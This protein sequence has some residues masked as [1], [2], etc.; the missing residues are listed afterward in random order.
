MVLQ[1]SCS[2]TLLSLLS[3]REIFALAP[4]QRQSISTTATRLNLDKVRFEE[5][6][7]RQE[8]RI[9]ELQ[10]LDDTNA[11]QQAE[12]EGLQSKSFIEQYDPSSFTESHVKFKRQHNLVFRQL[13]VYCDSCAQ[14]S[15]KN[16]FFLDGPD[17]GTASVLREDDT[18]ALEKCYIANRHQSTCDALKNEW[19]LLNVAHASAQN[20]LR[21]EFAEISFGAYYFDGCGGHLPILIEMLQAARFDAEPPIAVGVSLIGGGNRDVVNKELAIAQ[22]LVRLAKPYDLRVDHVLDDCEQY[23]LDPSVPKV[24][25]NTLTTWFLLVHR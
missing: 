20:A 7:A 5:R 14:R 16:I 24:D 1:I 10:R 18:I 12:L 22:A 17:A 19:G 4:Q 3:L 23:G 6:S 13:C 11:D 9:Y 8:A 2:I 25:G 21:D 15:D